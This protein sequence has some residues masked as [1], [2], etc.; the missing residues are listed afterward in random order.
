[1]KLLFTIQ[2]INFALCMHVYTASWKRKLSY[3]HMHASVYMKHMYSG[4]FAAGLQGKSSV[5]HFLKDTLDAVQAAKD[6]FIE[7]LLTPRFAIHIG[8]LAVGMAFWH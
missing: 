1:M 3:S 2:C 6:L 5:D 8:E 7:H 4:V